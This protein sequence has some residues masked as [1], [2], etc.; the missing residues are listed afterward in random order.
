MKSLSATVAGLWV[1]MAN[2]VFSQNIPDSSQIHML[3]PVEVESAF[4]LGEVSRLEDVVETYLFAGRKNEVLRV[5]QINASYAEKT[6]RRIY[7]K[8]P[9][10]F[11]YDMDGAGNQ[12]NISTRGLSAHRSWE[13][14]VRQNHVMLNSDVYAYPASHYNPPLE[15]VSRIELVRGTGALQYGAGFG[16]MLNYVTK[17]ADT[18]KKIGF[19][20]L[21]TVA[22]FGLF[23]SYNAVG[24]KIG[25]FEYYGYYYKR[26]S[27]GYRD[28]ARS[29]AE[30][31]FVS[32]QYDLRGGATLKAE[33]GRSRYLY[34]VPGPLSDSMFRVN[35]RMSTRSRN[36]YTPDIYVPSLCFD[37]RINDDTRLNVIAS[38]LLGARSS[39]LFIGTALRPDTVNLAMGAYAPRQVDIDRFNS[40]TMEARLLRAYR[41]GGS[42]HVFVAGVRYIN[43]RLH[44]LQLGKG[45]TGTNFDLTLSEPGWG[46]D[47]QCR[48]QNV[49]VFIENGFNISR[50]WS[51]NPGFRMEA[52]LTRVGGRIVYYPDDSVPVQVRRFFP[53]FG[54]TVQYRMHERHKLY[55]GVCRAYR[56]IVL[57]DLLPATALEVVDR[58]LKDARGENVEIGVAGTLKDR[59]TYD[60]SL[61]AIRY[62]NRIASSV[63][64]SDGRTYVLRSNGGTTLTLGVE[65]FAEC[66]LWRMRDAAVLVFSST[67]YM[68]ARYTRGNVVVGGE[69]RSLKGRRLEAAPEWTTRNGVQI[70]Y[71]TLSFTVQYGYVGE[72]FSDALNTREPK[73]DGT[74]GLVPAY[75]LWDVDASARFAGRFVLR[76]G[77]NNVLDRQ[78]FTMRPV[79]YPGPGVWPSDGRSFYVSLDV[80]I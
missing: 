67:S 18:T 48:T 38:A 21:N 29:D 59:L 63:A 60:A 32:M 8:I 50:R 15:S 42:G 20:S 2:G 52:G 36:F 43:N 75:D 40:Y 77:V 11:V 3:P 54:G 27:Q 9:G 76:A 79:I 12:I 80:S 69:N 23:A 71:R 35:A 53:L 61:F 13:Y 37:W 55:A 58:N 46:R 47:V 34:Q 6:A 51:F 31:Q 56:P 49:A 65:V 62:D 1:G 33:F 16:G 70:S 68:N 4:N 66:R 28:N 5:E 25:R 19:E 74:A 24:G 17:T 57:A 45:T 14:N 72:S 39:V 41:I 7:A 64:T 26:V 73:K 22:S 10:V 30:A 78:Y 44:R